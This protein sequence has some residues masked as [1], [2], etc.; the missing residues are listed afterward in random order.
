[1]CTGLFPFLW[2]LSP[3]MC[4]V[5]SPLKTGNTVETMNLEN[6]CVIHLFCS[7]KYVTFIAPT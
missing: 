4:H 7:T 3:L 5:K 1:M 2:E 6:A